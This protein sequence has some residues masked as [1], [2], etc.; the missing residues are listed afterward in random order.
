MHFGKIGR[1]LQSCLTPLSVIQLARD[2]LPVLLPLEAPD[3]PPL[4]F[5]DGCACH[6]RREFVG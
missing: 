2:V 3:S 5:A 1:G 4:R 6:Q